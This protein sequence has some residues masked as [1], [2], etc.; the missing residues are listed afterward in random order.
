[1]AIA[2]ANAATNSLHGSY[3]RG[4]FCTIRRHRIRANHR[5]GVQCKWNVPM[6]AK[7]QDIPMR[8]PLEPLKPWCLLAALVSVIAS[9]AASIAQGTPEARQACTPD[10]FRLCSEH[11]PDADEIA[12]CLR[13][14]HAELS[15]ACRKFVAAGTK[16]SDKSDSI[17]ARNHVAR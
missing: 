15:D 11:I 2:Y 3:K 4:R 7:S 1:M 5:D 12:A 10:A 8:G 9:P 16:S 17:D 6:T 14:R 13:E